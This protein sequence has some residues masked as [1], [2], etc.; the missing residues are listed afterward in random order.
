M[1]MGQITSSR[2]IQAASASANAGEIV[3]GPDINGK[4][5]G[6]S[7]C[8]IN[9]QGTSRQL[10][11]ATRLTRRSREALPASTWPTTLGQPNAK[12]DRLMSMAG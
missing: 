1:A 8:R 10:I 12:V 11:T 9:R 5:I 2:R 4:S 3:P 7:P 6:S